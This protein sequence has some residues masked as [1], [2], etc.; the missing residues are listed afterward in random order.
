ME[1]KTRRFGVVAIL[2]AMI[3]NL[4]AQKKPDFAEIQKLQHKKNGLILNYG[5][6]IPAKF[7]NQRQKRKL[8]RQQ[9]HGRK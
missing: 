9:P 2:S 7:L 3:A 5:G 6:C 4:H 1:R 8:A